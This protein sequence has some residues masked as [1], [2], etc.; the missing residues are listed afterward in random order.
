MCATNIHIIFF[1]SNIIACRCVDVG[2][3]CNIANI[4]LI[5]LIKKIIFAVR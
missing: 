4:L 1:L 3:L 5:I 2:C